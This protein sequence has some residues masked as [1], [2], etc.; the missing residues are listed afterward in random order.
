MNTI[1]IYYSELTNLLTTE[2]VPFIIRYVDNHQFRAPHRHNFLE[3]TYV[4]KGTGQ[5]T[6]NNQVHELKP[7]TFSLMLPYQVHVLDGSPSDPLSFYT[8]AI[9]LDALLFA[10]EF[11]KGV[12]SL[13]LRTEDNLPTF[14]HFKGRDAERMLGICEEM[15]AMCEVK[16]LRADLMFKTKLMEALLLF[17]RSRSMNDLPPASTEKTKNDCD[18]IKGSLFWKIVHHIQLNCCEHQTLEELARQFNTSPS[19]ISYSFQ[20]NLG[21]RYIDFLNDVRLQNACALLISSDMPVTDIAY[22]SGFESYS[23]FSRIFKKNKQMTAREYRVM[24]S[25]IK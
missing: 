11:W 12:S 15:M 23:T 21:T 16:T 25:G 1:P 9:T 4:T 13:L 3:F 10:E 17:D 22:E 8:G 24:Q 6:V 7:G 5:E 2:K 18:R 19:Y 14:F 20:K